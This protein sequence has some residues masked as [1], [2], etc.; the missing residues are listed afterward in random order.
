MKTVL[1]GIVLGAIGFGATITQTSAGGMSIPS[2]GSS[3]QSVDILF[4]DSRLITGDLQVT[5]NSFT[6]AWIGD[7]SLTLTHVDTGTSV[8]LM[9]RPGRLLSATSGLGAS[10][11]FNGTYVFSDTGT[12]TVAAWAAANNGVVPS[13]TY[14]ASQDTATE[15]DVA[16]I[17][18]TAFN[19]QAAGGT[20]RLTVADAADGDGGGFSNWTLQM[21]V[22][23][24]E[25]IPEPG[26]WALLSGGLA[27]VAVLRRRG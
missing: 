23:D 14:R 13:G 3:T 6:H 5:I 12:Q 1:M 27:L 15:D 17:I 11:D 9:Q 19:G 25:G 4:T 2:S 16:I 7:L 20:W 18:A 22:A 24:A 8:S 26:T 10:D 21:N